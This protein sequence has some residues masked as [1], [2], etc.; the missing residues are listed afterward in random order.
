MTPIPKE[1]PV[2][3]L[4]YEYALVMMKPDACRLGLT[5]ALRAQII[6]AGFE[7]IRTEALTLS[8]DQAERLYEGSR[9]KAHF[10]DQVDFMVSGPV[11]AYAV[12]H[13]TESN[14]CPLLR[15][16][17]G[18]TMPADRDPASLR[19]RFGDPEV[20]RFNRIHGSD[21]P[22]EARREL[23]IIFG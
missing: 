4:R 5:N 20:P 9:G 15:T 21:S 13:K 3:T 7:V 1:E 22:D 18:A 16:L 2:T 14:P 10:K 19:A 6:A 11:E 8:R 12:R 17:I 23:Q